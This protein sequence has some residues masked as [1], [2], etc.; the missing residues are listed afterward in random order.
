MLKAKKNL[1]NAHFFII[2]A[3][4]LPGYSLKEAW[5]AAVAFSY[6]QDKKKA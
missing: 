2:F 5:T 3:V 1:E 4:G 6:C